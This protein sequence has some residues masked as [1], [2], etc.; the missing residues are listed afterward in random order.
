V[1]GTAEIY[2]QVQPVDEVRGSVKVAH[3]RVDERRSASAILLAVHAHQ[4]LLTQRD[5]RPLTGSHGE[6]FELADGQG[7]S[8]KQCFTV[9]GKGEGSAWLCSQ[10]SAIGQS[11][12]RK[13]LW[14]NAK[15]PISSWP[16]AAGAKRR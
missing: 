15:W 8:G 13:R 1:H 4:R 14:K 5:Q 12:S 16:I 2:R 6:H 9:P 11:E 10:S 7:P 3:S